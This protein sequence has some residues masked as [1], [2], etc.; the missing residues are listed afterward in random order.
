MGMSGEG[1]KEE[2]TWY[3][4]GWSSQRRESRKIPRAEVIKGGEPWKKVYSF[5]SVLVWVLLSLRHVFKQSS[6]FWRQSQEILAGDWGSDQGEGFSDHH[7]QLKLNPHPLQRNLGTSK[8]C[9]LPV[10]RRHYLVWVE[11]CSWS[12]SISQIPACP[13]EVG[14]GCQRKSWGRKVGYFQMEAGLL[15]TVRERIVFGSVRD[16]ILGAREWEPLSQG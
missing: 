14:S 13:Q 9:T 3:L 15:C 1:K 8:R 11:C 5:G 10:N 2:W 16:T 7:G 12:M 4:P 6:L